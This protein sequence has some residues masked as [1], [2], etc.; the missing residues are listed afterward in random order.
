MNGIPNDILHEF[1]CRIVFTVV[2]TKRWYISLKIVW[3]WCK[4]I[5]YCWKPVAIVLCMHRAREGFVFKNMSILIPRLVVMIL[6]S[7]N[8]YELFFDDAILNTHIIMYLTPHCD[9]ICYMILCKYSKHI[10]IFVKARSNVDFPSHTSSQNG[11]YTLCKA[12]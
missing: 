8:S 5:V 9:I 10:S 1:M 4:D 12:K 11:M 2:A 7:S 6:L 3:C